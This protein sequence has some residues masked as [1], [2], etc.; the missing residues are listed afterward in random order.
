MAAAKKVPSAAF[1]AT[2]T[3]KSIEKGNT[4][5]GVRYS[6]LVGAEISRAGRPPF[7]RTCMAFGRE[8]AA[9]ARSL[10]EGKPVDLSIR[11]DGGSIRI[12]GKAVNAKKTG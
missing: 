5:N 4:V 9:V 1:N 12:L 10:K 8:N 6:K 11:Y 7:E 2:V 3:P